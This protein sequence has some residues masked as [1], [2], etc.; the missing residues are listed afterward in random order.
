MLISFSNQQPNGSNSP[1]AGEHYSS[2]NRAYLV[3]YL[4]N[5]FLRLA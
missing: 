3:N 1:G 2:N 5:G 4:V